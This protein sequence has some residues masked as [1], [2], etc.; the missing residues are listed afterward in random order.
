MPVIRKKCESIRLKIGK[1]HRSGGGES[2]GFGLKTSQVP[3]QGQEGQVRELNSENQQIV[4]TKI[5]IEKDRS[6]RKVSKVWKK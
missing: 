3:R 2:G 1:L 4:S 6:S 5:L